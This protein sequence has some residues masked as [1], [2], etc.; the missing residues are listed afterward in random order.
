MAAVPAVGIEI[1]ARILRHGVHVR[2]VLRPVDEDLVAL[3]RTPIAAAAQELLTAYSRLQVF[4]GTGEQAL[5]GSPVFSVIIE[6]KIIVIIPF[7]VILLLLLLLLIERIVV[8]G[9]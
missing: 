5:A 1:E 9:R 2:C 4:A 3:T 7:P 8:T 6:E